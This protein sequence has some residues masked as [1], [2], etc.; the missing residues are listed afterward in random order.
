MFKR[1]MLLALAGTLSL[2]LAGCGGEPAQPEK[3]A[4]A[5]VVKKDEPALP[6]YELTKDSITTHADWTSKNVSIF[7]AKLN[8]LTTKVEK[9]FGKLDNTRTLAEEYLT[10]YQ[11]NGLFVY[12]QKT[13]GKAKKFEVYENMAKQVA[14]DTFKKLLSTGDLK[15]MREKLGPEEKVEEVTEDQPATE[16][17]YDARGFRFVQYKVAGKKVSAL[18]FF[19]PKKAS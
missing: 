13:T 18:R 9:E 6:V 16:Y 19:E 8:D 5:P 4:A 7:G 15:L 3:P 11:G 10:V 17:A 14:D 1:I 12:T 2:S